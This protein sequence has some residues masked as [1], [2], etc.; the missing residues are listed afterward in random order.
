MYI[1]QEPQTTALY[2]DLAKTTVFTASK[3]VIELYN[4]FFSSTYKE[5]F[6]TYAFKQEYSY[7]APRYQ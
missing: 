1:V 3:N 5:T 4:D 6:T 2:Q 7:Y